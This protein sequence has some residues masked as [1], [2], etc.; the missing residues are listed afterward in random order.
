M[1]LGKSSIT[2]LFLLLLLTGCKSIQYVPTET[3]KT[4]YRANTVHDSIYIETVK[5]DSILVEKQGDTVLVTKYHY[6]YK[7]RWKEKT[8]VD[9]IIKTDSIQVPYPVEKQLSRWE[10]TCLNI[11][12]RFL[13]I[14]GIIL[15]LLFAGLLFQDKI[16]SFFS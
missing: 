13:K 11:G 9:T 1:K 2:W 6:L 4:E 12:S 3:V 16:K 8:V 15:L 10:S 14:L 5:H 7:D